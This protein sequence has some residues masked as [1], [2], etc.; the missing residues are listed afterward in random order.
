MS[1][2]C[3]SANERMIAPRP[4]VR[5]GLISGFVIVEEQLAY[6]TVSKSANARGEAQ[7]TQLE[8]EALAQAPVRQSEARH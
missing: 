1:A 2:P 7:T 6:S 5:V 3:W 8:G 4:C